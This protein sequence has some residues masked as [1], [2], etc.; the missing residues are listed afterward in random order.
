MNGYLL[1]SKANEAIDHLWEAEIGVRKGLLLHPDN[2]LLLQQLEHVQH[3][4][5]NPSTRVPRVSIT[6]IYD[7]PD[8]YGLVHSHGLI[9][10]G[11]SELLMV[12]VPANKVLNAVD[13]VGTVAK[14]LQQG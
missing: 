12:D 13:I 9:W 7:I 4:R 3:A 8:K 14:Q 6:P 2:A 1:F 5:N 11:L 10:E